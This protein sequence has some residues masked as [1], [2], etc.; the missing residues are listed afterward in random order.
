[1]AH[2][3]AAFTNCLEVSPHDE[4]V[5]IDTRFH[6]DDK[7]KLQGGVMKFLFS[8]VLKFD[9]SSGFSRKDH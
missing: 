4:A 8:R 3:A 2:I 1:M 6:G 5:F 9:R 7:P